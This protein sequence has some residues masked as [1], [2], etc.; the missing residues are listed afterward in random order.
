[1]LVQQQQVK[2]IEWHLR[3]DLPLATCKI[4]VQMTEYASSQVPYRIVG[5]GI[6]GNDWEIV[7]NSRGEPCTSALL[8][9]AAKCLGARDVMPKGT[10]RLTAWDEEIGGRIP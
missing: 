6:A 8:F 1:M 5:M 4:L 10:R 9:R 2:F 7:R 3:F